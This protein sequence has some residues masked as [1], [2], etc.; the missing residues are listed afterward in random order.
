MSEEVLKVT[1]VEEQRKATATSLGHL[2]QLAFNLMEVEK[3]I[4]ECKGKLSDTERELADFRQK[5]ELERRFSELTG[6]PYEDKSQEL[7]EKVKSL[8]EQ[9]EGLSAEKVKLRSEILS[10]LASATLPIEPVG[11]SEASGEE[12]SFKFRDGAKYPAITA[13]I[14][15][16]LNFG[17]P[18]VYVALA[19]E[20]LKVVGINDKNAAIKEVIKIIESLRAKASGELG[21]YTY[22]GLNEKPT[23]EEFP[24]KGIL[25]PFKKLHAVKDHKWLHKT[26]GL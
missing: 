22:A 7:E 21:H 16:E 10:G 19:P 12:V 24:S 18:P 2:E 26:A 23:A 15:K 4:E 25:S 20:G 5:R 17:L 14:K 1:L 11:C 6:V 13:F 3:L 8:K 9:L